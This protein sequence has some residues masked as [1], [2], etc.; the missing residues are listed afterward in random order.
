MSAGSP[1]E[2]HVNTNAVLQAS[3]NPGKK[4]HQLLPQGCLH[5]HYIWQQNIFSVAVAL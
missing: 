2:Q 5:L 3:L 4:A 1:A